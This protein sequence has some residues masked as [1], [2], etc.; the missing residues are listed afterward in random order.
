MLFYKTLWL[1][2]SFRSTIDYVAEGNSS[3][4]SADIWGAFYLKNGLRLGL[5]YDYSLTPLQQYGN[6][7]A[8]IMIGYDMNF[9]VEKIVT[10]RYF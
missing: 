1:G 3:H 7:S 10:P 2:A 4:D 5:A 8:E 9:N 6:G